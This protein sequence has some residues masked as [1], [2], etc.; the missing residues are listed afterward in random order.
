MSLGKYQQQVEKRLLK[1]EEENFVQRLWKRDQTL[2]LKKR[3]NEDEIA[4]GWLDATEKMLK[5]LPALEAFADSVRGDKFTHMV[6]LGM[7]GSSLAPYVMQKVFGDQATGLKLTVLDSTDPETIK[8]VE[9]QIKVGSTLFIVSS[10][11][12]STAEVKALYNYFFHRVFEVKG[13]RSG[14]NFIAITDDGSPLVK[15]AEQKK[16]RAIFTNLPEIGGRYSALSYF[17]L[18]PAALMGIN[19]KEMLERTLSMVSV[20]KEKQPIFHNPGVVLGAAIAEAALKGRD[21]LTYVMAPGLESFGLWLEQLIAESTGKLHRG[22]LPIKGEEG[23]DP[24]SYG[25]DRCFLRFG[26]LGKTIVPEEAHDVLAANGAPV[27]NILMRDELDLGQEFFRWEIAT[28]TAGS[29]LGLNPFDQPNVEESKKCTNQLLKL[30]V[31]D[32]TLPESTPALTAEGIQYFNGKE[33][34]SA[35]EFIAQFFTG[36]HLGDYITVQAYLPEEEKVEHLIHDLQHNLEASMHLAVSTQFGPRYLHSTGQYHKGGPDNGFFIQF[37]CCSSADVRI[38]EHSYTF[39]L[40]KRAQAFGDMEAL[41]KNG[42]R[43]IL[44]DLG[45]D[46]VNGLKTFNQAVIDAQLETLAPKKVVRK[47]VKKHVEL[48]IKPKTGDSALVAT[49]VVKGDRKK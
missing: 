24:M 40:L 14:Q 15:L 9:S 8:R 32:G 13:E 36:A 6:L 48:Q 27:I 31:Q 1:M 12:G 43:V 45:E 28:A 35:K 10:K 47:R 23:T 2:W 30:I 18:V 25:K 19:V 7:G 22:I 29:I 4:M 42:R 26:I 16:F 49:M 38:P 44:V 11:S 5:T 39:G 34:S 20:C 33:A 3:T 41:S 17:G 37:T 46:Y 21:K